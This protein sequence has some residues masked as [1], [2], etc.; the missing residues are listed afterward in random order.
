MENYKESN[1]TSA[2]GGG[3]LTLSYSYPTAYQVLT[4]TKEITDFVFPPLNPAPLKMY[5]Y[6][7]IYT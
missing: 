7:K 2:D 1:H 3:D 6:L 5:T 4:C